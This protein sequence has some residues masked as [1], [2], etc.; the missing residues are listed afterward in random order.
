MLQA[1]NSRIILGELLKQ[2]WFSFQKKSPFANSG[3]SLESESKHGIRW[4][5]IKLHCCL[6]V[7]LKKVIGAGKLRH[8]AVEEHSSISPGYGGVVLARHLWESEQ[9]G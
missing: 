9:K 5:H 1:V 4:T 7:N 8:R 3:T 6:S 2:F